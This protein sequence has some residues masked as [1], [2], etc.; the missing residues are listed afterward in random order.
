MLEGQVAKL[1]EK[2]KVNESRGSAGTNSDNGQA[3]MRPAFDVVYVLY[4]DNVALGVK[5]QHMQEGLTWTYART[6][7]WPIHTDRTIK[8]AWRGS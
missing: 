4:A 3:L 5:G 6:A 1:T 7:C 2:K 8:D